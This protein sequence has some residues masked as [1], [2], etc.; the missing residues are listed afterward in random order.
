[1]LHSH[2]HTHNS[3]TNTHYTHTSQIKLW[4]FALNRFYLKMFGIY[5]GVK[6]VS[7]C[8]FCQFVFVCFAFWTGN[9]V[10]HLFKPPGGAVLDETVR[11][12][13]NK[14]A[15][16]V[17]PKSTPLKLFT[18]NPSP[19]CWLRPLSLLHKATQEVLQPLYFL[20]C[21]KQRTTFST[22]HYCTILLFYIQLVNTAYV[23]GVVST[24]ATHHSLRDKT[25]R[26]GL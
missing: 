2:A 14:V 8:F 26:R 4:D 25:R 9:G 15:L 18:Y 22:P 1:M 11:H 20:S 12:I 6:A 21:F 7:F 17:V 16:L 10:Y 3:D 19:L 5:K 23:T 13:N 24:A